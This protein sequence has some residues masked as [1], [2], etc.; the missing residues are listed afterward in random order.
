LI[1]P[2]TLP[3]DTFSDEVP[4]ISDALFEARV[5]FVSVEAEPPIP[6]PRLGAV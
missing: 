6:P 2:P 3:L 5:L 1:S 4:A